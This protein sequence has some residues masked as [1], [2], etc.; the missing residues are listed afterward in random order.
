MAQPYKSRVAESRE[1][2]EANN[3]TPNA[4]H[5][6][7]FVTPNGFRF[8]RNGAEYRELTLVTTD[9]AG[10]KR[11]TQ[12]IEGELVRPDGERCWVY[13]GIQGWRVDAHNADSMIGMVKAYAEGSKARTQEATLKTLE[14]IKTLRLASL[15]HAAIVAALK[16][17]GIDSVNADKLV[18]AE[19]E[20]A[21]QT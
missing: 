12:I 10:V 3:D 5:I 6:A 1:A 21:K 16:A 20:A 15:P 4:K 18:K 2:M 14:Q 7:Y 11:E 19:A 9:K 17:Q 8:S 13:Q